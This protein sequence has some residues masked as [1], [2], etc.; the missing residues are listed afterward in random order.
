MNLRNI[1]KQA[2]TRNEGEM[3]TTE[4]TSPQTRR[5]YAVPEAQ[6]QLGGIGR[7]TLYNLVKNG[8]L[9][10]VKI[11]ARTFVTHDSL[12]N[13]VRALALGE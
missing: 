2:M 3:T 11:G 8:Q 5:I 1:S 4:T 7:T 6:E 9:Q 12:E 10:I 13:Y